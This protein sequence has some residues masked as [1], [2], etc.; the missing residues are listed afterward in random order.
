[1]IKNDVSTKILEVEQE[2]KKVCQDHF[3]YSAYFEGARL[4]ELADNPSSILVVQNALDAL[5]IQ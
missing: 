1:M 3:P 5:T 2:W 4:K